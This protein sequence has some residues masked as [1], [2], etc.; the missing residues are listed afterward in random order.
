MSL[1]GIPTLIV[2]LILTLAGSSWFTGAHT[3]G[4]ILIWASV[5][6]IVISLIIFVA[7]AWFA[8]NDR[9]RW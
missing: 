5:A 3:V 7:I 6:W 8:T 9:P 4:L 2:G 1:F